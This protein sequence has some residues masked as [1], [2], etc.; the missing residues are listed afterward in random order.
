MFPHIWR[1]T[2]KTIIFGIFFGL[3]VSA[4]TIGAQSQEIPPS[5]CQQLALDFGKDPD[6]LT[7]DQLGQLQFCINQT[8]E[9]QEARNPPSMLKGTIIEPL[10]PFPNDSFPT[11]SNL[12]TK[13]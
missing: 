7:V 5:K 11:P 2:M 3:M 9:K 12:G 13:D 1:C 6:A 10:S 4:E 8:L